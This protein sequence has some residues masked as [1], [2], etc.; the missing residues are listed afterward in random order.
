MKILYKENLLLIL[1][2]LLTIYSLY[3]L[4]YLFKLKHIESEF[5]MNVTFLLVT[6]AVYMLINY[7]IN[8][9]E[10]NR[11][12]IIDNINNNGFVFCVYFCFWCIL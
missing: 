4:K 5:Y 7:G 12:K 1:K 9:K 11:Q 2:I 10:R 6:A 8:I 3:S